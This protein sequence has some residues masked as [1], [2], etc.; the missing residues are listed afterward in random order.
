MV[1][2]RQDDLNAL[3]AAP[4][5]SSS[6]FVRPHIQIQPGGLTLTGYHPMAG[7]YLPICMTAT[8]LVQNG[9]LCLAIGSVS[10]G[11]VAAPS[12]VQSR[13][14]RELNTE[15]QKGTADT[16]ALQSVKACDGYL[17]LDLL[18]SR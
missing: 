11:G 3:L 6:E 13:V 15:I 4:E 10:A 12:S 14:E 2:L 5:T 17:E 1:F 7:G 16:R 18:A 9:R 8:P